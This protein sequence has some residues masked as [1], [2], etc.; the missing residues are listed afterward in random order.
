MKLTADQIINVRLLPDHKILEYYQSSK[1][2]DEQIYW[3]DILRV[4]ER[5]K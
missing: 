3:L 2:R 5:L 4:R 1:T